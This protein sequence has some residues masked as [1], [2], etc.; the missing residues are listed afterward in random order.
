MATGR[1]EADSGASAR[2]GE[3]ASHM[4]PHGEPATTP[5][6]HVPGSRIAQTRHVA[7]SASVDGSVIVDMS[8]GRRT[9]I[10]H[11]GSRLLQALSSQPTLPALVIALRDEGT[12]AE[13]LAEDVTRLL[14]RWQTQ[15][16]IDWR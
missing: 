13:R 2:S 3:A 12:S 9:R 10:E 8:T 14:A 11:L 7:S 6:R 4:Q 15:G 5:A 16:M 1:H